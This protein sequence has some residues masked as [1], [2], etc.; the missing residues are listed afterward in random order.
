MGRP[1]PVGGVQHHR[2]QLLAAH[3]GGVGGWGGAE[4]SRGD[5]PK[6][7]V[8]FVVAMGAFIEHTRLNVEKIMKLKKWTKKSTSV[9]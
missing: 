2:P 7:C 6:Q 8:G 9:N 1:R 4:I 3:P 5:G